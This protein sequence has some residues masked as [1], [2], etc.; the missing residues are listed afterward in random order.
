MVKISLGVYQPHQ[1]HWLMIILWT[2]TAC[3][4]N[5]F[6]FSYQQQFQKAD[7][8]PQSSISSSDTTLH[9]FLLLH[10]STSLP[11]YQQNRIYQ[12]NVISKFVDLKIY[13]S[14]TAVALNFICTKHKKLCLSLL[15]K[16]FALKII[17]FLLASWFMKEKFNNNKLI[18]WTLKCLTCKYNECCKNQIKTA[19]DM[20][21]NQVDDGCVVVGCG[22]VFVGAILSWIVWEMVL[23]LL[24]LLPHAPGTDNKPSIIL[25]IW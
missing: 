23:I 6:L 22:S 11:N 16:T 8:Q 2:R 9:H 4:T 25:M 1:L 10:I 3:K 5:L 14:F 15:S 13:Q 24:L 12:R 20:F 19:E 21:D 7:G 18:L 17:W